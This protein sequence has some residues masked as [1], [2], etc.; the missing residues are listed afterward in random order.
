[1]NATTILKY[2]QCSTFEQFW[3]EMK[4]IWAKTNKTDLLYYKYN[5]RI[6]K[7]FWDLGHFSLDFKE[8]HGTS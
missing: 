3:K 5:K 1:M 4:K 8:H 7:N 6:M 2:P